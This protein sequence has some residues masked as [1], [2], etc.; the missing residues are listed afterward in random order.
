MAIQGVYKTGVKCPI[1]N[2]PR[3]TEHVALLPMTIRGQK[4]EP[5]EYAICDNCYK[6]QFRMFYGFAYEDRA[7]QATQQEEWSE[8]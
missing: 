2:T 7:E 6:D 5:H 4:H 3:S 1:C 8:E